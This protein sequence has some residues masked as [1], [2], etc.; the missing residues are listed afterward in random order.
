LKIFAVQFNDIAILTMASPVAFTETIS[1]VC[2][3]PRETNHQ[4]VGQLAIVKGWGATGEEEI[5]SNHLLHG[6]LSIIS[7]S[8]CQK[9]YTGSN[10][11]TTHMM[12]AYRRGI[13]SCQVSI[14]DNR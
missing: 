14:D 5:G 11:I 8:V 4:Y 7:N 3:P 13:D 9:S 1:P 12:C 10:K 2:L 6:V